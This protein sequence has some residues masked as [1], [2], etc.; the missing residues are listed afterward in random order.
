MAGIKVQP[1]LCESPSP[2]KSANVPCFDIGRWKE[3]SYSDLTVVLEVV[4]KKAL[5]ELNQTLVRVQVSITGFYFNKILL[6]YQ[7]C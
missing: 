6:S 5:T 3:I 4:M 1:P 7:W 2:N